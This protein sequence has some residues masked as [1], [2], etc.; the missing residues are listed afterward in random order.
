MQKIF[1]VTNKIRMKAF[2]ECA[3]DKKENVGDCVCLPTDLLSVLRCLIL[4]VCMNGMIGQ[5]EKCVCHSVS[6]ACN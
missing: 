2:L 1:C 4:F 3:H 5:N 6:N